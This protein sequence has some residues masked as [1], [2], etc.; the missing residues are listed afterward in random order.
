[1][2][3]QTQVKKAFDESVGRPINWSFRE[4]EASDGRKQTQ[5]INGD[6][7]VVLAVNLTGDE[8]YQKLLD[9]VGTTFIDAA[10]DTLEMEGPNQANQLDKADDNVK[11]PS[12]RPGPAL[13]AEKNANAGKLAED[14]KKKGK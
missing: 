5:L 12:S 9:N 13:E 7:A 4:V 14:T 3:T 1:M 8:A 11:T 2:A 6:G 10:F